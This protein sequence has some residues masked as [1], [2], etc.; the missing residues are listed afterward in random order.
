MK[1]GSSRQRRNHPGR[2]AC[3]S[4]QL[5]IIS[6]RRRQALQGGHDTVQSNLIRV[7]DDASVSHI[8]VVFDEFDGY[9]HVDLV[10]LRP[11][12]AGKAPV[13][14]TI[15][16]RMVVQSSRNRVDDERG[17]TRFYEPSSF[18]AL[19]LTFHSGEI[20]QVRKRHGILSAP[21]LY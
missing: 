20:N 4:F 7:P 11:S 19:S 5:R 2:E 18:A 1:P 17:I 10:K 21:F 13:H 14:D 6:G 3:Q 9:R 12:V 15:Q 16:F 8:H